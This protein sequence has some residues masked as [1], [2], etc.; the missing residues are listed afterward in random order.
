MTTPAHSQCLQT[1]EQTRVLLAGATG[2]LGGFLLHELTRRNYLTRVVVRNPT[3]LSG[4]SNVDIRTAEVTQAD[5]LQGICEDID[6]VI[7]T[8]GITRQKDGVT[9]M[10]VDYQANVNLI[11]EAL[12]SG[13]KRFIYI[14]VFNG[15]WMRQLKI[16]EAKERLGDYLKSSGLDYCIIRPTGFFSDMRDFLQMARHG[17]VW[18][19]GSGALHMNPIHGLDLAC[20]IVDVIPTNQR[21]VNIGGPDVLTQNQIAELAL[22][23]CGKAT[24]I[25][26]LPDFLRRSALTLLR[27]F[28][29]V[30]TY[31]PLEFFLT[32]MAMDMQAP[33]YGSE[34]L[35][36][37]FRCEV[38]NR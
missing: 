6:V 16:C 32:A 2:Y 12:H 19:F 21:E 5:T 20:A 31:G 13:V 15:E 36:D 9:Y 17:S 37:F 27:L 11:N 33:V 23:A 14:S 26:H 29:S 10:D 30:R 24:K 35:E 7:S 1:P 38:E 22:R 34:R 8:V 4:V 18:L 3:R 28:T 25:Y